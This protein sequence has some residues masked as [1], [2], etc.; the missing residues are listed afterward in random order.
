MR[1]GWVGVGLAALVVLLASGCAVTTRVSLS[2][3]RSGH[4]TVGVSV[5]LD[6]AALQAVGGLGTL[7]SELAVEDLRAAGWIVTGPRPLTSGG[8]TVSVEHGFDS[9]QQAGQLISDVAGPGPFHLVLQAHRSFWHTSYRLSGQ[10][11]LTCGLACFGD[12][13][14]KAATGSVVGVDPASVPGAAGQ[15]PADVFG[16]VVD[17]RLPG[18]LQATNA[19]AV[20]GSTLEWTPRLGS[21]LPVVAATQVAN[22][23]AVVEV[24]SAAAVVVV[25]LAAGLWFGWLRGRR[26]RTRGRH[27]R[28][29]RRWPGRGRKKAEAVTPSS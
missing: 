5:T 2:V 17:A 28:K 24:I 18:R 16:F 13:A 25:G 6:R 9:L 23:T 8:A 12:S 26:R 10:V 19:T 1:R 15:T 7:Q 29:R 22:G 14:L 21:A 27:S 11:D 4:G 20:N 3:D